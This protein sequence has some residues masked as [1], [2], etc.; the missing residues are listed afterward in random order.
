MRV[1]IINGHPRKASLSSAM[2]IAFAKGAKE[3]GFPV[4]VIHVCD[5]AFN[6][7]GIFPSPNQQPLEDD[8]RM[9]QECI[10]QADHLVFVYPLVGH[11]ACAD[12]RIY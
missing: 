9:A 7:N 5:L 10:R 11:H 6:P 8:L 1:L 4:S 3:T 2:A 12:E